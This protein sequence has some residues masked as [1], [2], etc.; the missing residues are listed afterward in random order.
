MQNF[1]LDIIIRYS[2]EAAKVR[3]I[4]L[5]RALDD[6]LLESAIEVQQALISHN[7]I[8]MGPMNSIVQNIYKQSFETRV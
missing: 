5:C 2:N 1:L 8:Q 7:G 3:D 4:S 6:V